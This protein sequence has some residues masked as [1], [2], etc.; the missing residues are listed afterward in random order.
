M[1]HSPEDKPEWKRKKKK[2][3]KPIAETKVKYQVIEQ[4]VDNFHLIA[5]LNIRL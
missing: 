2:E 1:F 4:L 3:R 5:A